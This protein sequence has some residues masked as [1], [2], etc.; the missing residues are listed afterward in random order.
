MLIVDDEPDTVVTLLAI[1]RD[2]GYDVRGHSSGQAAL[3][4]LEDFDP[5]VII[6]DIAMPGLSGWEVAKEVRRKSGGR[7]K[8]LMIAL[9][10][11]YKKGSDRILGEISGF[12][13]YL[14]KPA[15]PQ[16]LLS[17]IAANTGKSS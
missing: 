12:N 10:G 6:S 3:A 17:L 11:Q 5:D 14:T 7:P 13:F 1:L 8:P 15:D 4:V 2:E 16:V 9:T